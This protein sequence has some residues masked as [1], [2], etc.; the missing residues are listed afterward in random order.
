MPEEREKLVRRHF[1]AHRDLTWIED[2]EPRFR[3]YGVE[4]KQLQS[5]RESW[6]EHTERRDW[7]WW[8]KETAHTPSG[9]LEDE[10]TDINDRLDQLGCIRWQQEQVQKQRSEYKEMLAEAA[11]KTPTT[12]KDK[13]I[14]R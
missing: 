8:Q 4:G 11:N 1:E 9:R 13:G 5:F 2:L 7:G 10:I 14:D 12:E 3:E 6:N